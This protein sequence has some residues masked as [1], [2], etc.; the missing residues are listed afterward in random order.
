MQTLALISQKGG[1]GKS[2]LA[3]HLAVEA[4]AHGQRT[5]LLDL[6]PQGSAV[7]WADRRQ[8]GAI[9]IDAAIEVPARLEAALKAAQAEGYDQVV[10]DTAPHSDQA[11][12]R[13]ARL[14]DFVLVPLRC[15][16]LD[17]NAMTATHELCEM[18]RR[19]A[20][21]VLNAAPVRSRVVFETVCAMVALGFTVCG[22]TI[23][24][25]VAF[26][27][28]LID[29]RVAREFEPNGRAAN[30]ITMLYIKTCLRVD[31]QT[32]KEVA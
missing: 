10:I 32:R 29:G 11:A 21:V 5:L 27:H 25:R 6:D 1:A 30:E 19:P 26:R 17:I 7:T 3:I 4:A 22:T 2:T 18:A 15:S 16:I 24:E 31:M 12:L 14:A 23:H 8:P 20:T 9:D 28:A 13:A